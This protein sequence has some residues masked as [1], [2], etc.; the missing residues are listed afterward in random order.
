PEGAPDELA[1]DRNVERPER[2][3]TREEPLRRALRHRHVERLLPAADENER[4]LALRLAEGGAYVAGRSHRR[5]VDFLEDVADADA[6]VRGRTVGVHVRHLEPGLPLLQGEAEG[7][8]RGRGS[9]G[10]RRLV[11]RR[12]RLHLAQTHA[13]LALLSGAEEGERDRAAR[14]EARHRVAKR[15]AV[16]DRLAVD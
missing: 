14:L 13:H 12:A 16:R 15:I 8:P 5:P 11:T 4:R 10:R 6:R 2:L 1:S 3:P 7:A 9:V